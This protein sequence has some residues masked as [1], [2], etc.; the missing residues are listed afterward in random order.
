MHIICLGWVKNFSTN[1]L[2]FDIAQ[3]FLSLNYCFLT[4]ILQ[5]TGLDSHIVKFFANYLT[6]MK[7]NY[8]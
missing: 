3:F 7:T 4:Y 2:A 5:K 1:T 6:D 8:I